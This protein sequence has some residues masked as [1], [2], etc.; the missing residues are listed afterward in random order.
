MND[1]SDRNSEFLTSAREQVIISELERYLFKAKE[2]IAANREFL[3]RVAGELLERET[4]LYSDMK[5]IR[6]S[7][8]ITSVEVG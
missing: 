7:C 6:Q 4:L 2:I 8:K 3:D 1:V 5:R